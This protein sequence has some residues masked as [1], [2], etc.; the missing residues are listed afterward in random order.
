M[1]PPPPHTIHELH[2]KMGVVHGSIR[3][4]KHAANNLAQKVDGLDAKID[5]MAIAMTQQTHHQR[6]IDDHEARLH[7]LEVE[8]H[9]RDGAVS[10]LTWIYRNW[11]ITIVAGLLGAIVMWANGKLG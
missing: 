11:P 9:H 6:C 10:V 7:V 1:P 3:E 8:K 5:A 2:E 4:M